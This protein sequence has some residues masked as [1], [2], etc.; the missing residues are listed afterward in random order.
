MLVAGY[1][2]VS[3]DGEDQANSFQ[4]QQRY[5]REYIARHPEWELYEIYA[6][7][8]ISGTSTRKRTRFLQML[9]DAERGKFQL[10]LTKEVSRF[11][12]NLLDTIDCTR[13]LKKLGVGVCFLTDGI[14]TLDGDGELRLSI[15]ASIAQEESRKTSARVK[16]GQQRQMERGVVFGH[17]LLGYTLQG[18]VLQ[19]EPEGAALVQRIYHSYGVLQH[20]ASRIARELNEAGIRTSTGRA[21]TA[22]G[23]LKVLK[24]EKYVGD[25]VQKK[26]CTPDYLSHEKKPNRGQEALI[27]LRE[28]HEGLVSRPLWDAVQAQLQRRSRK[29]SVSGSGCAYPLSGKLFCGE[30]GA[31]LAARRRKSADG[32]ISLRWGCSRAAARGRAGCSIGCL[33]PD[34]QA[35]EMLLD[36]MQMQSGLRAAAEAEIR[37]EFAAAAQARRQKLEAQQQRLQHRRQ[38]LLE[39]CL[40]GALEPRE[41]GEL[42]QHWERKQEEA[43]LALQRCSGE[44]EQLSQPPPDEALQDALC[45]V[46]DGRI[47]LYRGGR[48]EVMLPGLSRPFVFLRSGEKTQGNID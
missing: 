23:I 3:T 20:S 10:I 19:A 27:V 40:D 4:A 9:E 35:R 33:L 48:A 42:L 25:L 14:H 6:D 41:L 16:W 21:W 37:R 13:R 34:A 17:S 11:S 36:V 2:R 22:G 26:S 1:C 31:A 5:F 28:H 7:E 32:S 24:N 15:M 44:A 8:G 18:G 39:R 45:R 43:R 29:R 38:E 30:C 46:F 12:R 47:C